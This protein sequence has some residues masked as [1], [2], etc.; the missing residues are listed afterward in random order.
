MEDELEGTRPEA[1]KPVIAIFLETSDEFLTRM[2][3]VRRKGWG[4]G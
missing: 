2:V 1:G 3:A 4:E